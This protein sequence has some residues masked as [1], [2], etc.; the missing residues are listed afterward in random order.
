MI[1]LENETIKQFQRPL[2]KK[3]TDISVGNWM[4]DQLE[5]MLR[6]EKKE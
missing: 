3:K 4:E 1:L 2:F 5:K 6:F